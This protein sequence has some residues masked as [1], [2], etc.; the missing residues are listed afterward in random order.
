MMK[1]LDGGKKEDA[2]GVVGSLHGQPAAVGSVASYVPPP[3][4]CG[5]GLCTIDRRLQMPGGM[6]LPSR[7]TLVQLR[8][9]RTVVI[10]APPLHPGLE[11]ALR[12]QGGVAAVVTPNSF[13]HA[14]LNFTDYFPEAKVYLPPALEQRTA[15]SPAA[16][17]L[18]SE[19][20]SLW[21]DELE[22]CFFGPVG[23]YR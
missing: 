14:F 16:L 8:N 1:G 2:P 4:Q 3:A 15:I 10:S 18:N 6:T 9:G 17:T 19:P 22:Q 21:S 5:D 12:E 11:Y 13:H 20:P 23:E 7:S